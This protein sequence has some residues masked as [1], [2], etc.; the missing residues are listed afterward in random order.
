MS[1][2]VILFGCQQIAIDISRF[3][4]SQ[5]NVSLSKIITYEVLSDIS[6]GQESIKTVAAEMGVELASPTKITNKL[7]Q[8]IKDINPDLIVSA[9]YRQIFPRK[10][11]DI[12]RL[13]IVNIHPSILPYYRGPVPTAWAIMNNESEFGITVHKVDDSIDTGDILVQKAFTIDEDETGYE[14]YM[15]AMKLGATLFIDNFKDIIEENIQPRKQPYG[16]SYYGK[17]KPRFFLD[18]RQ[19]AQAIKNNVRIRAYPYNPIET[20]LHNKYFFIN[21]V[22]IYFNDEFLVQAP[23]KILRVYKDDTFLV[24]CADGVVHVLDYTV[25]PPLNEIEKTVCLKTGQA[26]K[27][28]V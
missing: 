7:M 1:I 27:N 9:Y 16:G 28:Y 21:K 8:E 14:L 20:V 13:G 17:L 10:L 2:K 3:L 12:P 26:F 15:K 22:A 18:W 6:R 4:H 11:I 5:Q 23:G 19:S 25:Y 24:S